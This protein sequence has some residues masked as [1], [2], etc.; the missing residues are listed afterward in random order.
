[1]PI[2]DPGIKLIKLEGLNLF[3]TF[4]FRD[5]LLKLCNKKNKDILDYYDFFK[6][7][8]G[9]FPEMY[10]FGE[11]V[12]KYLS[13]KKD[14]DIVID[15]Q[16]LSL[17]ILE[18]QKSYPFVEIIHHPITKDFKYDLI[19]SNGY[20]QR[21]FKKR[22]YSFLKMNKKVAPKLKKIITVSLNSKKDIAI[23]F[24]I[25]AKRISIIPNGLDL[26]V[27]KKKNGLKR[28]KFK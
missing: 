15:N 21:F 16:S 3:E 26:E 13:Q 14:Y 22:W 11:R 17:G 5:R 23:D 10:S 2:L 1:M 28:E 7:L 25:D 12:K 24:K 19:Y 20:I 27:F 9:G 4:S 6:T 18:I 8:I